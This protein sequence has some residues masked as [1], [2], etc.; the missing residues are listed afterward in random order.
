MARTGATAALQGG[1]GMSRST[2][3]R[4]S[5]LR[6]PKQIKGTNAL[7]SNPG[8]V[9]Q[10]GPLNRFERKREDERGR[11]LR[12]EAPRCSSLPAH[13]AGS[14]CAGSLPGSLCAGT[15]RACLLLRAP[16]IT[17][18]A[19]I[20]PSPHVSCLPIIFLLPADFRIPVR[21]EEVLPNRALCLPT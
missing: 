15:Q 20:P 7:L 17:R 11:G 2:C 16:A 3:L 19:A 6:E 1:S 18:A 4:E 10:H 12:G 8:M 5:R 13:C 21:P 14:L 9:V